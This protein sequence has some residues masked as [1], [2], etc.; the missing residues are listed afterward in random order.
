MPARDVIEV[1]VRIV[2]GGAAGLW[3]LD[4]LTR[5]GYA[6]LLVESGALGAGQT[7]SAQGIIHGGLKYSLDGWFSGAARAVRDMPALWRDCLAG[8]REPIL[9]DTRLRA[10]FCHLWR[11]GGTGA[12]LGMLGA[13]VGLNVRPVR[14][15]REERPAALVDCPGDVYRVDEPVVDVPSL[16][17]DLAARH[18]GRILAAQRLDAA[19]VRSATTVVTAGVG[20][21]DVRAELGLAP[22]VMQRRPLHMVMVRGELPVLFGHCVDAASP[23]VTIT[24]HSDAVGRR[25][26]YVGG[27]VAEDGVRMAPAELVEHARR[28]LRDVLPGVCFDGLDWSTL[29]VDRAE[30]RTDGGGRPDDVWCRR[31]GDVITAWPTKLALVPRLAERVR[32]LLPPPRLSG[33]RTSVDA[34]RTPPIA[35]PPWDRETT[36]MRVP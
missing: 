9:A 18:R 31:E 2:G 13:R 3:L 7:I 24:T 15:P 10:D 23:R 35:R 17:E 11:A 27:R 26:W 1:D 21:A 12:R 36:W 6:A 32:G 8:R 20:A 4:D 28:E 19:A 5:A 33:P 34:A 25:V 14:V 29:R 30:G 22:N 16:L